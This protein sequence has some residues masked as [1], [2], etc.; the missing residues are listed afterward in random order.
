MVEKEG[1]KF[2]KEIRI[3]SGQSVLD[4]GCGLGDYVIRAA[5]VGGKRG[6]VYTVGMNKESLDEV[7]Q[8][9]GKIGL[10]N[11]LGYLRR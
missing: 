4:Y 11:I 1:E 5:V 10:K 2:L 3:K 9:A 7:M 8:K 6:S